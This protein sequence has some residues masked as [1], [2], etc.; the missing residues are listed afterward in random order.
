MTTQGLQQQDEARAGE[1]V[2]AHTSA[3]AG[4]QLEQAQ[5]HED[6]RPE[7]E[8]DMGVLEAE[9]L[10]GEAQPEHHDGN[11]DDKG[12]GNQTAGARFSFGVH[13]GLSLES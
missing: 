11:A 12:G 5:H 10:Q 13:D 8:N 7:P 4:A 1:Q 9:I 6:D 2:A 3:L